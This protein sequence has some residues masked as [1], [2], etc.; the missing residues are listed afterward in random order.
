MR[1]LARVLASL[2]CVLLAAHFLRRAAGAGT[3][4]LYAPVLVCLA[5]PLLLLVRKAWGV[6][7]LRL[8]LAAGAAVW[9]ASAIEFRRERMDEGRPAGRLTVILG[10]VAAV[11][12][13]AALLLR[14]SPTDRDSGRP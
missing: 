8:A 1:V 12:A 3:P 14:P 6:L 13:L 11:T 4:L 7:V 2:A 10:S 5:L 9:I